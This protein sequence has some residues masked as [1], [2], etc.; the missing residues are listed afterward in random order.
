MMLP[1]T[2]DVC[3]RSLYVTTVGLQ[4]WRIM[5]LIEHDNHDSA[6]NIGDQQPDH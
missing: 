3:Q 6:L 1:I 4:G 5:I 2:W